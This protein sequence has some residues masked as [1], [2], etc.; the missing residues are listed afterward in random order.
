[1]WHA[2]WWVVQ[3]EQLDKPVSSGLIEQK[4]VSASVRARRYADP[5]V[6]GGS[7]L[8]ELLPLRRGRGVGRIVPG[9]T[10]GCT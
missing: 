9:Q 8:R 1:M 5:P 7:Y 2:R 3:V 6:L 4:L 10:S